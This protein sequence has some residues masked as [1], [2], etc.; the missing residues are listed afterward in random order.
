MAFHAVGS[1]GTNWTCAH[2]S[3]MGSSWCNTGSCHSSQCLVAL[4]LAFWPWLCWAYWPWL[5]SW[6]RIVLGWVL[7]VH[8]CPYLQV[9]PGNSSQACCLDKF[10]EVTEAPALKSV[11]L[12]RPALPPPLAAAALPRGRGVLFCRHP[13]FQCAEWVAISLWH[14]NFKGTNVDMEDSDYMH[15]YVNK[16][17]DD[18]TLETNYYEFIR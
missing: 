1:C 7:K 6:S 10:A 8:L 16:D 17:L 14:W 5:A 9:F 12:L 18:T 11:V 13:G 4:A 2:R 15:V 3:K